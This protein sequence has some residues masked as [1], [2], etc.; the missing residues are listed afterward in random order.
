MLYN[1]GM[2]KSEINIGYDFSETVYATKEEVKARYNLENID[3][4]YE[5]VLHYRSFYDTETEI[6][7]DQNWAYK[8]CLTRSFS[9][10]AYH[11][12]E[13][14]MEQLVRYSQL[15][16]DLKKE[17]FLQRK[18]FFLAR[19]AYKNHI[20]VQDS[21]LRNLIQG[22]IENI[23]SLFY[24]LK[25]YLDALNYASSLESLNMKDIEKI[26]AILSGDSK[27]NPTIV[28]RKNN[29]KD[30]VSSLK[31]VSMEKIPEMMN[32]FLAFLKQEEIPSILRALTIPYF[33]FSVRPFEYCNEETAA[34]LSKA[35][36]YQNH[37]S[38]IG[39][40]L[41]FE[42]ICFSSSKAVFE[43]LK[44]SEES[45]DLTYTLTRFI[46]FEIQSLE[47]IKKTLDELLIENVDL[48]KESEEKKNE[49]LH[50]ND[51]PVK[52]IKE[53]LALPSF[54]RNDSSETIEARARKLREIYPFLKKRQAHFYA[55][56][57]TIG[58]NYAIE[59]FKKSENTVYETARTSM[60]DLANRGFYKK[61]LIGKKFVYTPLPTI[62]EEKPELSF[63][64]DSL[65][66]QDD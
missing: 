51:I 44:I 38:T 21:T 2:P 18:T 24:P 33:F 3:P 60:E 8:I 45:L 43:K 66:Q 39:F 6:R 28:Y 1:S 12:Q 59:E 40:C 52:T 23:P 19:L 50:P 55:G 63:E 11:F 22:K 15:R 61:L 16:E 35:F 30:V 14:C 54:P 20:G 53:D 49:T 65:N 32:Q 64:E 42:S 57:C 48:K 46:P 4:I 10:L 34:L 62:G 26:N 5:K 37:L 36:L 13:E 27:E 58:L 29:T 56:H 47:Q 17:F 31:T 25:A 41:D 9:A 7:N